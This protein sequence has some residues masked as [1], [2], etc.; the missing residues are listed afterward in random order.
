MFKIIKDGTTLA[1]VNNPVWVKQQENGSFALSSEAEAQ[2]VVVDG[3]VFQIPGREPLEGHEEIILAHIS[4]ADYQKEQEAHLQEI[5][6]PASIVFVSMAEAKQLD[7]TTVSEHA[8]LFSLWVEGMEYEVGVI[9]KDPENENLY[10]CEQKHTSQAG[11]EPHATPAMWTKIGDPA[12]EYPQW[13]QPI[14][15]HD[16]YPQ[17]AKVTDDGKRWISEVNNNVWKPGVYGWAEV[18]EDSNE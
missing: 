12:E 16:S 13:S 18:E 2:G 3:T 15:S 9:R 11:W 14:G 4:E 5:S 1:T 17:G 7:D 8:N 10:R 6:L